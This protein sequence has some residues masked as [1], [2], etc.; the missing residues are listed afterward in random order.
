MGKYK[1]KHAKHPTP[2]LQNKNPS[3]LFPSKQNRT[4]TCEL[5]S[6]VCTAGP[7]RTDRMPENMPD[8]ISNK[9]SKNIPDKMPWDMPNRIPEN[10]S[11]RMPNKIP[12]KMI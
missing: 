4:S 8:G 5:P 7:Q 12:D 11:N 6:S 10:I 2:P 9:I 1:F 3:N